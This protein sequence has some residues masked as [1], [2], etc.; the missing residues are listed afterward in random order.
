M[1][2]NHNDTRPGADWMK[3]RALVGVET[4]VV[5]WAAFSGSR[6]RNSRSESPL[7]C[8]GEAGLRMF[9]LKFLLGD[10]AYLTSDAQPVRLEAA[11]E[12]LHGHPIGAW[13]AAV[14]LDA[15]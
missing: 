7:R 13:R 2:R 9:P 14:L 10:K 1:R 4:L 5:M 11:A 6:A 3:C 12:S 15:S 8:L